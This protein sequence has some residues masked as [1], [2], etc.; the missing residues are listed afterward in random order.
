MRECEDACGEAARAAGGDSARGSVRRILHPHPSPARSPGWWPSGPEAAVTGAQA[1]GRENVGRSSFSTVAVH[2]QG[3]AQR[4]RGAPTKAA[5][6]RPPAA[7]GTARAP[8]T[9]Q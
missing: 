1:S 7:P 5:S 8:L 4:A 6:L 2:T 9:E 3:P